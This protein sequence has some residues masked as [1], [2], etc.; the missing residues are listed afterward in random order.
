MTPS[1]GCRFAQWRSACGPLMAAGGA[2]A[3]N[4]GGYDDIEKA[5]PDIRCGHGGPWALDG[6]RRTC[7]GR[8]VGQCRRFGCARPRKSGRRQEGR[9]VAS[10]RRDKAGGQLQSV[11]GIMQSVCPQGGQLQSV[12][13]CSEPVRGRESLCRSE[14]V[15]RQES[16]QPLRGRLAGRR[17]PGW[18]GRGDVGLRRD[19]PG[20]GARLHGV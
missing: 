18:Q 15:Q 19:P 20:V 14:P 6:R 11:R 8:R 13:G 16:L 9:H 2:G 12:R 10:D 17:C 1:A 3:S 7:R 5:F 4:D